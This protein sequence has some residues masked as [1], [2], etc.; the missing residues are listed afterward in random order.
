MVLLGCGLEPSLRAS[1]G[2]GWSLH[3]TLKN[4]MQVHWS[5]LMISS[6]MRWCQTFGG[7][8]A[9]LLVNLVYTW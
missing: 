1:T 3:A 4:K 2:F 9:H 8:A 6:T 7:A 5:H